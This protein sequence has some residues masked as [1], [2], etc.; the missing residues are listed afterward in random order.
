MGKIYKKL[1]RLDDALIHFNIALDLKPP[2]SDVNLIKV[3][4]FPPLRN[5]S[6]QRCYILLSFQI[7][8]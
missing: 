3:P 6:E 2:S 8:K 7:E 4:P 5:Q 1:E